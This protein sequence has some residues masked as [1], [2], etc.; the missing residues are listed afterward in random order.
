MPNATPQ[1]LHDWYRMNALDVRPAP[2][3]ERRWVNYLTQGYTMDDLAVLVKY[4]KREIKHERRNAGALLLRNLLEWGPD[5][6][7]LRLDEDL[8]LAKAAYPAAPVRL[9]VTIPKAQ[10]P[11]TQAQLASFAARLRERAAK[12]GV[13]MRPDHEPRTTN[14]EQ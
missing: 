11:A 7:F 6:R 9:P 13:A 8:A 3:W 4:L 10:P 12:I 5:N 2:E 14:H 1:M